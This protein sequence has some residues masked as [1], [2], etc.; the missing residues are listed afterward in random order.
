MAEKSKVAEL[1]AVWVS[2]RTR[3][4]LLLPVALIT[5]LLAVIDVPSTFTTPNTDE[6]ACGTVIAPLETVIIVPSG[7]TAPRAA[8]VAI[9][10]SAGAN[11][12]NV[13][14]AALPDDGP[15]NTK[16]AASVAN[17]KVNVPLVVTGEPDTVKIPGA[18]S[19]TL[20]TVPVP[21]GKS[22]ATNDLNVGAAALP[23]VGPA[24]TKLAD[25]VA[26][27]SANV[28]LTVTGEPDT[29]NIPGADKPTLVTV[30]VPV[31]AGKSA[32]TSALKVGVAALPDDGPANI[33]FAA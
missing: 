23:E 16:F 25:S 8:E 28:P 3:P 32:A 14:A 1:D 2:R 27:A 21:D 18:D 4:P 33:R 22:A 26:N 24:K 10:K 31:P 15:A 13:G 6:D 9:G 30:P 12:R 11:E 17:A 20:V 5:P 19:P 7:C 29:V